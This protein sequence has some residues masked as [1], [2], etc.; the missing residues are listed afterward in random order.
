ML[1]VMSEFLRTLGGV[2][3]SPGE[4]FRALAARPQWVAALVAL[5]VLHLAFAA[6][7]TRKMD[8]HLAVRAQLEESGMMDRI[9][10]EKHAEFMESQ[11]KVMKVMPWL[12]GLVF[13]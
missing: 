13:M 4:A 6:V 3:A 5:V 2:Y 1:S 9:P 7:W 12:G 8:A 11:T 10:A